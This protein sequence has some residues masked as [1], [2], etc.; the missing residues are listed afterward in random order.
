MPGQSFGGSAHGFIRAGIEESFPQKIFEFDFAHAKSGAV[1][2]GGD[3]VARHGFSADDESEAG[4]GELDVVGGLED[5]F[6]AGSADALHEMRRNIDGDAGVEADVA[7]QNVGVERGL[8]HVSGDDDIDVG[9]WD[10]GA[11]EDFAGGFDSE[12][13]GR[14]EAE[15]SVVFDERGAD[16]V[17][18]EDVVVGGEQGFAARTH[19]AVLMARMSSLAATRRGSGGFS[20]VPGT[21]IGAVGVSASGLGAR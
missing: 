13:G 20:G 7:R 11:A 10:V 8:R 4:F 2:V 15:S 9:G 3:G 21:A 1:G 6:D 5:G 17:K 16:A 19:R 18:E 14:D 12:V